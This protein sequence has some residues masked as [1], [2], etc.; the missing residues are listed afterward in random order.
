MFFD[1]RLAT[2][3]RQRAQ[4]D[5][6]RRTQYRQLL[7]LLG[8]QESGA[9]KAASDPSLVAAAWMRMNKLAEAIPAKE[10]ALLVNEPGWRLRN[11]E[12]VVHL[13]NFEPD[14]ASAALARAQLPS[15][16]WTA[17]IPRLPVRARGFLRLRHDLPSDVETMLDKLGIYDRGLPQPTAADEP[18][19]GAGDAH[20]EP[21]ELG[22]GDELPGSDIPLE[23]LP[24]EPLVGEPVG[25][26]PAGSEDAEESDP[27]P[28]RPIFFPKDRQNEATPEDTAE[29]QGFT[30]E[31]FTIEELRQIAEEPLGICE[32]APEEDLETDEASEKEAA[33]ADLDDNKLS[34][35]DL[36]DPH[37][38]GLRSDKRSEISALVQRISNFQRNKERPN[39]PEG[40]SADALSE[41]DG[42]MPRL[43][44]GEEVTSRQRIVRGF[45]FAADAA[46]RIEW[47]ED[48]VA[49]MV[50]GTRLVASYR[51]GAG[52]ANDPLAAA[53]AKRQP[54]TAARFTINGAPAIAGEWVVDAQPRFGQIGGFAGYVGRMR[55]PLEAAPSLPSPAQRE[56][57]RIRQL[58]HELR[59]PV[60]AVQ[61]Y[62]EVIQQQLFGSAP[63]EYRALAAAIASDA[64]RILSGFEELDRL[65]KL[66][67]GAIEI[68]EGHTDIAALSQRFVRQLAQVLE[69][70]M[71]GM[72][73]IFDED[74]AHVA[75]IEEERAEN[76]MWRLL[77]SL[78]GGSGAGE[79]LEARLTSEDDM[80]SLSC[81]L[82]MQLLGEDDLFAVDARP[83]GTAINPGIFGAGFA[84]RLARAEARASGGDLVRKEEV[85]T[86]T[87]PSAKTD[88]RDLK[89]DCAASES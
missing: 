34:E 71:A 69:A 46:G 89:P 73:L 42:L 39:T 48:D 30:P 70:R 16:D 51:L 32:P 27:A 9:R 43:P 33:S 8:S 41:G 60:T 19:A 36:P 13:A 58:L 31:P 20:D 63:H 59:T 23:E 11:P 28:T 55:R 87:L 24:R 35:S 78:G 75:A 52:D 2:V 81:D 56:A 79:T 25:P 12:L 5:S 49:P 26:L 74:E 50:M 82:P 72:E 80:I 21:L 54:I 6:M 14:V 15:E 47:A 40:L 1:D 77:A 67:T 61:G 86:L 3:L 83:L 76:L 17:L 38:T 45:G 65:A 66:E 22:T 29:A 57:D 7:D 18:L 68:D 62:S 4:S 88:S 44:L 37:E 85:I 64:A 84:L 53:F 10:R